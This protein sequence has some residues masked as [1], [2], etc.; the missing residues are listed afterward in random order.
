M[1]NTHPVE[2]SAYLKVWLV[3]A[4]LTLVAVAVGQL[5][6]AK[7]LRAFLFVLISVAKVTLIA[8]VFMHLRLERVTLVLIVLIPVMFAAAMVLGVMPDTHDSA[9]RFILSLR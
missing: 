7:D 1:N 4:V 6:L 3:L 5:Q 8:A 9:T 2:F